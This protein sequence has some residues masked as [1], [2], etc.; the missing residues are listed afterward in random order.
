MATLKGNVRVHNLGLA[1]TQDYYFFEKEKYIRRKAP[2]GVAEFFLL[3]TVTLSKLLGGE[4]DKNRQL[5]LRPMWE[6]FGRSQAFIGAM[7]KKRGYYVST[8]QGGVSFSSLFPQKCKF[9]PL[10]SF[11]LF[12]TTRLPISQ[13][14]W[15]TLSEQV[16][17][18]EHGFT[19]HTVWS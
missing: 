16:S 4:S 11:S 8:F 7:L 12:L 3:G 5:C 6:L 17:L 14:E 19:V 1:K 9:E 10:F 15:P 13:G 2:P 18:L